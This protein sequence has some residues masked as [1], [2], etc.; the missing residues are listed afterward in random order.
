LTYKDLPG[1]DDRMCEIT[2]VYGREEAL[3]VI[4]AARQDYKARFGR[5]EAMMAT[6][7]ED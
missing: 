2:H 5:L 7:V 6:L 3:E 1:S 4:R